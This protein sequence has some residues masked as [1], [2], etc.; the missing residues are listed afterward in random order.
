MVVTKKVTNCQKKNKII[1]IENGE[2][3]KGWFLLKKWIN[4]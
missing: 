2:K 3:I 1:I 4:K